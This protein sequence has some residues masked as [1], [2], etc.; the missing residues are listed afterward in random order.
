MLPAHIMA[1]ERYLTAAKPIWRQCCLQAERQQVISGALARRTYDLRKRIAVIADSP[2]SALW[3]GPLTA[4]V[5]DG[6]RSCR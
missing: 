4:R 5:R 1:G 3:A 2:S 6:G